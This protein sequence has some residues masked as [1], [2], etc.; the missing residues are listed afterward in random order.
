MKHVRPFET[1][2]SHHALVLT[3]HGPAFVDVVQW[4]QPKQVSNQVPNKPIFWMFRFVV[5]VAFDYDL[6]Q[7]DWDPHVAHPVAEAPP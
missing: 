3:F 5:E 2:V 1:G 7:V 4:P 6:Q